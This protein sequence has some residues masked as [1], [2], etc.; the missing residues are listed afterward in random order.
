MPASEERAWPMKSAMI[1]PASGFL[2]KRF[3]AYCKMG[4]GVEMAAVKLKIGIEEHEIGSPTFPPEKQ[5]VD[6]TDR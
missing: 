2:C 4:M 3:P 5:G 1:H 6:P